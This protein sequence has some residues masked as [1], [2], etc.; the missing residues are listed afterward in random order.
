[1]LQPLL[2]PAAEGQ[3]SLE[4]PAA[5]P[6]EDAVL[7]FHR[8]GQQVQRHHDTM[9]EL[10]VLRPGQ[11]KPGALAV[12]HELRRQVEVDVGLD[13]HLWCAKPGEVAAHAGCAPHR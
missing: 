2:Q 13:P 4:R 6:E 7:A 12:R 11:G 9:V 3:E 5:D 8:P 10:A 1:M